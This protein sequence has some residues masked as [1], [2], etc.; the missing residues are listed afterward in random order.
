MTAQPYF[1]NDLGISCALG[2]GKQVV[3]AALLA[4][5][6]SGMQPDPGYLQRGEAV[7]GIVPD[8]PEDLPPLPQSDK[9]ATRSNRILCGALME[10]EDSIASAVERYGPERVG[11]VIGA[12]TSGIEEG[13][14]ALA[15][16]HADGAFA[17][18]FRL[19]MQELGNPSDFVSTLYQLQG[20]SFTVSNACSSGGNALASGAR[21]LAT[22]QCDAVV[23][24]GVDAL[25]SLTLNGFDALSSIAPGLSNPFS[26]NRNGIN[27]GEGAA[28]F[29]MTRQHSN[30][31]LL[32]WGETSDGYHMNA[33]DPSGQGAIDA[34]NIAMDMAGCDVGDI[35]YVNLHGTGTRANDAMESLAVA[36]ALG[37]GVP[38]S[39]TKPMTGHTLGAAGAIE[40]GFLWLLL[41]RSASDTELPPHLWD[42]KLG[43]D[44]EPL[45]FVAPGDPGRTMQQASAMIS[46]SFAFGGNN[47]S[48]VLGRSEQS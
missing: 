14:L 8:L 43:M 5:D 40:A 19:E 32:G 45:N 12:T 25:T 22:G 6:Q 26:V 30:V 42:G 10:V 1:L 36:Q 44:C 38:V 11:V 39:S 33:P 28:V 31:A 35:A 9:F 15:T 24:G 18:D 47:C 13:R 20:P 2:Q 34:I 29:L 41:S 3:R 37:Q 27:I 46:N 21:L 48:L 7:V 23:V 17:S 16:A 4:G